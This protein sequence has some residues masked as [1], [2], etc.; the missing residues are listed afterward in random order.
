MTVKFTPPQSIAAALA[1][2]ANAILTFEVGSNYIRETTTGNLIPTETTTL[3]FQ[4]IMHTT[5]ALER[6]QHSN[7]ELD[8]R[9]LKAEWMRGRLTNPKTFPTTIGTTSIGRLTI[10]GRTG[11][12]YLIIPV[13]N[14]YVKGML[15]TSFYGRFQEN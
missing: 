4:A 3:E 6:E 15:G 1:E 13:Q 7:F 11:N 14:P 8:G 2:N 5:E 10:D 12:Y 9:D